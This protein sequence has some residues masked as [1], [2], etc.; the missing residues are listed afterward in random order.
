MD[1]ITKLINNIVILFLFI[2]YNY[3]YQFKLKNIEIINDEKLY[4]INSIINDDDEIGSEGTILFNNKHNNLQ[5]TKDIPNNDIKNPS[6]NK[7]I[8]KFKKL[9]VNLENILKEKKYS[10]IENIILFF[11]IYYVISILNDDIDE[12]IYNLG[13]SIII[14]II[15][16]LYMNLYNKKYHNDFLKIYY[17]YI[18][19]FILL[20]FFISYIL[21]TY[22]KYYDNQIK[23]MKNNNIHNDEYIEIVYN[24][25]KIRDIIFY[26]TLSLLFSTNL[27]I[28]VNLK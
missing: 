14:Y 26:I 2:T 7:M 5:E 12:P 19:L 10:I 21:T 25:E 8:N 9:S 23:K 17:I 13:N 28:F 3:I 22:I 24:L 11:I 27:Y 6:E 4:N 16:C 15:I 1:F 20:L 18:N